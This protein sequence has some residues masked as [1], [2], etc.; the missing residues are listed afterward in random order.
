MPQMPKFLF[1]PANLWRSPAA[2]CADG[3]RA[4]RATPALATVL[5]A[6]AVL[7]V[8]ATAARAD[9]LPLKE[10]PTCVL[11]PEAVAKIKSSMSLGVATSIPGTKVPPPLA[12]V[13]YIIVVSRDRPYNGQPVCA[14]PGCVVEQYAA[15]V[16]ICTAPPIYSGESLTS[17]GTTATTTTSDT[18]ISDARV[19]D[20]SQSSIVTYAQEV[21][22]DTEIRN[23]VCIAFSDVDKCKTLAPNP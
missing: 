21:S 11:K 22:E 6:V 13:D 16:V 20:A 7:V 9:P 14:G 12:D 3:G 17:E 8:G 5:G 19:Q 18:A 23:Q 4:R 2:F 15:G 10:I 1:D